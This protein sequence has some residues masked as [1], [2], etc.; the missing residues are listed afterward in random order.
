MSDL[1]SRQALCKYALN[2]KDKSVTPNDIMRFPSAQPTYT[3]EEI[4][5]MQDLESAEIEKAYQIGYEEGKRDALE[6]RTGKW[7]KPTGVM[8]PEHFGRHRC[9]ECE[10]FAM[11]DW[12]HH[13][14]QLTD[15]CPHCG[16]YMNEGEEE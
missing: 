14:E 12:K 10:G 2:Q 16:A 3:D 15:F 1:I 13:K 6:E 9:S 5:K 11:Q 4:Q 7:Y 8:P